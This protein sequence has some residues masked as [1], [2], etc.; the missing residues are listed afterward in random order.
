M[1][2]VKRF[3]SCFI[4]GVEVHSSKIVLEDSGHQCFAIDKSDSLAME[5]FAKWFKEFY[6]KGIP[7]VLTILEY[8]FVE[9]DG[10]QMCLVNKL[11]PGATSRG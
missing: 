3:R 11:I 9:K 10:E 6:L 1:D 4:C 7:Q 5:S 8:S 2:N